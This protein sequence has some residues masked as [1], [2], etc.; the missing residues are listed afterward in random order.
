MKTKEY[1]PVSL[2]IFTFLI[3][4]FT[5][6]ASAAGAHYELDKPYYHPGDTGCYIVEVSNNQPGAVD[7]TSATFNITGIGSFSWNASTVN[8]S[9]LN[10]ASI[11]ELPLFD[12]TGNS[13]AHVNGCRID[14]GGSAVFRVYFQI[15]MDAQRGDY[16]Y[17]FYMP[18]MMDIPV[19]I[20]GLINVYP[21]G[22]E[23][24]PDVF[25][26]VFLIGL[27]LTLMFLSAYL[28]LRWRNS[29]AKK[30]AQVGLLVSFILVLIGLQSIIIAML[31]LGFLIFPLW[32][33]LL[34]LLV[35]ALVWNRRRKH[36]KEAA[37]L[38]SG[39]S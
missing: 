32:P 16:R 31:T 29:G 1:L 11:M 20:T 24:K 8:A 34:V 9:D 19:Q 28:I 25:S 27:L 39:M 30:Y 6:Q 35:G 21:Q 10:H 38:Q 23:P 13:Y 33:L 4:A 18:I 15:P 12:S 36:K 26:G 3:V 5:G 7:I 2:L 17:D 22:E 37:K 14:V